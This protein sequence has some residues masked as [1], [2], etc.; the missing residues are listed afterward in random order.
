MRESLTRNEM[1]NVILKNIWI[2]LIN[3]SINY[4]APNVSSFMD[5]TKRDPRFISW[6][7]IQILVLVGNT[8]GIFYNRI[9]NKT[10]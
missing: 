9:N 7:P 6:D 8:G 1:S 2:A 3:N 10:Q 4:G 5:E